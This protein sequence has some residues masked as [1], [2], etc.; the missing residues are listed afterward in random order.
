[1][2]YGI[3]I[4]LLQ[5]KEKCGKLYIAKLT[6]YYVKLGVFSFLWENCAFFAHPYIVN[7]IK[8][9]ILSI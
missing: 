5:S 8:M 4:F 7:L 3:L 1:M 6:E 2:T 9:Q